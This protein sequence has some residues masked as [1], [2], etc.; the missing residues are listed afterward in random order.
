MQMTVGTEYEFMAASIAG[1]DGMPFT[2]S[3]PHPAHDDW[4]HTIGVVHDAKAA[5]H[6]ASA[7]AGN[8]PRSR[9][10][11]AAAEA[12]CIRV[13]AAEQAEAAARETAA[14][15]PLV[16]QESW[17]PILVGLYG[18]T[19]FAAKLRRSVGA[20]ARTGCPS[21]LLLASKRVPNPDGTPSAEVLKATAYGGLCMPAQAQVPNIIGDKLDSFQTVDHFSYG[22]DDGDFD[23][24]SAE[25][26]LI[27]DELDE[28]M[29]E[30]AERI[31]AEERAW[32]RRTLQAKLDAIG[33]S[34][35]ADARKKGMRM[36][37]GRYVCGKGR[38]QHSAAQYCKHNTC[39][40]TPVCLPSLL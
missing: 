32:Y 13:T 28:L 21:C 25:Q 4:E 27:S 39:C 26:L 11:A 36:S 15:V 20:A 18:D 6:A 19:P 30:A 12:A 9:A 2:W 16:V 35:T 14:G 7:E 38:W 10:K 34:P 23:K 17:F 5:H 33:S 37:D 40:S 8:H 1:V 29:A 31:T 24:G 3:A 22:T